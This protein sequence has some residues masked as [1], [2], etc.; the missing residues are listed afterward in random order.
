MNIYLMTGIAGS[1][2]TTWAKRLVRESNGKICLLSQDAIREMLMGGYVYTNEV[3]EMMNCIRDSA[4][5]MFIRRRQDFVLDAV[6]LT[7]ERRRRIVDYI[8][9]SAQAAGVYHQ[10]I[11]I[12]FIWCQESDRNLYFKLKDPRGLSEA[13]WAEVVDYMKRNY[14]SPMYNEMSKMSTGLRHVTMDDDDFDKKV[15]SLL[16]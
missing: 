3:T 15:K 2:K 11:H 14:Q 6:Q 4:I 1:G 13:H 8:R 5:D 10:D 7:M 9:S 16:D 12:T